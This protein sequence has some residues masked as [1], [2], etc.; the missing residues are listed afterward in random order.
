M[1]G[2]V[3]KVALLTPIAVLLALIAENIIAEQLAIMAMAPGNPEQSAVYSYT[4][5]VG[6]NLLLF[7][8]LGLLVLLIA[9]ALVERELGGGVR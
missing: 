4:A 2:T 1:Y 9:A 7:L 6:N 8:M 5:A 3:F